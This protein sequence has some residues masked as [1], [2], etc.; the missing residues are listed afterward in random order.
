MSPEASQGRLPSAWVRSWLLLT[1]STVLLLCLFWPSVASLV[2]AWKTSTFSHGFLILPTS[3]YLVWARRRRLAS[4]SPMPTFWA[5]PV[6]A[7]LAL[8]W[9][10]GELTATSVLEHFTV[11][12]MVIVTFWGL[13]GTTVARALLLPL[14]F[15]LF[16]VPFG[17]GLIPVLQNFTA[18]FAVK[19]LDL[20]GIPVLLEGRFI[21][22][23]SGRWEVAEACSG[24]RYLTASV[25]IGF[26]FAGLMYR[27]WRRRVGFV[28]ASVIVPIL[29]NGL[30][31]Y[32]IVLMSYYSGNRIAVGV[33]HLIYGGLFYSIVLALLL[34]IGTW[35]R[36]PEK[37]IEPHEVNKP[38]ATEATRVR[39]STKYGIIAAALFVLVVAPFS[40]SAKL[41]RENPVN[42]APLRL[43]PP[44]AVFPWSSVSENR[45]DW[46]PAFLNPTAE[47]L[48]DYHSGTDTVHLYIACYAPSRFDAKLVSSTN[49]LFD[50]RVWSRTGEAETSLS[51][52]GQSFR[53]RETFIRSEARSLV[54]SNWYWINGR[55]TGSDFFAKLLLAP[56]RL[57]RSHGGAAAIV[58]ATEDTNDR[59]QAKRAVKDFLAHTRLQTSLWMGEDSKAD[60]KPP[61]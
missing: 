47:V 24:I 10:L 59:Q 14:A 29:A 41:Y 16:A 3:V 61:G 32:G 37:Q 19:M 28:L 50:R 49:L 40:I 25:A 51:I 42:A 9:L 21:A 11:V 8:G 53:V 22:V 12:A 18:R 39:G 17:A 7:L 57:L 31:V 44:L 34:W 60:S 13:L 6:L 30:R 45:H 38:P 23:P 4:L 26:L 52:D 27:T 20:S 43:A 15:L 35:W 55:F 54:I 48:Q 2:A 5:F 56:A 33:D 36:E 1:G 46:R 58:V